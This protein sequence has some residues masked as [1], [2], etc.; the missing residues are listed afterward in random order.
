MT[1][2][3]HE[4]ATYPIPFAATCCHLPPP[5][6][7]HAVSRRRHEQLP[8]RRTIRSLASHPQFILVLTGFVC[9]AT[10]CTPEESALQLQLSATNTVPDA[11]GLAYHKWCYFYTQCWRCCRPCRCRRCGLC[12]WRRHGLC[13]L[14]APPPSP[15]SALPPLS[16]AALQ[17]LPLTALPP[18]LLAALLLL[19]LPALLPLVAGCA[20]GRLVVGGS[21]APVAGGSAIHAS[22]LFQYTSG[23]L[24]SDI[25]NAALARRYA[26][27]YRCQRCVC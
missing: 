22:L 4:H 8:G 1:P 9:V 6:A 17:P 20:A 13:R 27:L 10:L 16:L 26:C 18:L 23:H 5:V 15:L 25:D 21:A 7:S 14:A 11:A 24:R 19:S 12:C 3:N 2:K